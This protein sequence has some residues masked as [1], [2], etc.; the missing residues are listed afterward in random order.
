MNKHRTLNTALAVLGIASTLAILGP[1]LDSAPDRRG[2]HIA[3]DQMDSALK[4]EQ[5]ATRREAA[6]RAICEGTRGVNAGHRWTDAGELVCTTKRN[7]RPITVAAT[8]RD[9]GSVR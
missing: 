2:E 9:A 7:T 6:A 8:V 5:Q 4:A 1:W 3:A